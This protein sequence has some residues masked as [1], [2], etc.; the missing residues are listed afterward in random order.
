MCR[1]SGHGDVVANDDIR[2]M[3]NA[4]KGEQPQQQQQPITEASTWQQGEG[5]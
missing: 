2:T 1:E 3:M 4:G 5:Q